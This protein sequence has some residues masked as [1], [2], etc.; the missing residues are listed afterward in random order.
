MDRDTFTT[1]PISPTTCARGRRARRHGR[2]PRG[3]RHQG[4]RGD[5]R[6]V[7]RH[8]PRALRRRPPRP[9]PPAR[10]RP[11]RRRRRPP[12]WRRRRPSSTGPT[13]RTTWTSTRTTRRSTRRSTRSPP[14]T[15]RS[16]TTRR[17][18]TGN[19]EFVAKIADAAK[20]GK[21][22]GW[23]IITLTDW[24]A[25][26]LIRLGW[27]DTFDP[28]NVPNLDR[29]PQ[30]RLPQPPLG[31]DNSQHAPWRSG[32][33]GPGLRR[34]RHRRR[35]EPR[36]PVHRRSQDWKGKVEYLTEMRDAIGPLDAVPRPRP[37][38]PDPGRL[39]QGRRP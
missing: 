22:T 7:R 12:R 28:A 19:D 30:G 34:R 10:P 25:A 5:D 24:M 15:A 32:H 39:R 35:H 38:E 11:R 26:K 9:R 21:D 16:S 8:P 20:A 1:T 27:V 14:S 37:G 17:S 6:P 31:P 23:D 13:G 36:G 3:V 2:I 4:H 33:D 29:Q 18:S